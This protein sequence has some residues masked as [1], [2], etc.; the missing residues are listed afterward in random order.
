[1][2]RSF[3]ARARGTVL[4]AACAF[5]LSGC[6]TEEYSGFGPRHLQPLSPQILASIEQKGMAK[7]SPILLRLFKEES[8]REVWKQT[9]EGRFELLKSYPICRWSGELGPKIREGDRQAPEGF[10]SIT[11]E[12]MN[13]K[14]NFY[15]AFNLG[16][17]NEFDRALNRTGA[18]L[19][20]HGDCSSRGCYAMTDEQ[21]QE[22]FALGREAFD[23]GQLAFQ[24]QAYPFH[25]TAANMAR[26]RNSPHLVFWRML[27]EGN[28]HFELSRQQPKI[29]VCEK[30]YVYDAILN[31]PSKPFDPQRPCPAYEVPEQLAK[32]V[33][34]K[35]VADER[36]YTVLARLG[37]PTVPV[38][39]GRDGGMNPI[40]AGKLGP[41]SDDRF[42]TAATPATTGSAGP[43]VIAGVPLPPTDPRQRPQQSSLMS[44]AGSGSSSTR[45]ASASSGGFSFG[46]MFG[47]GG[48]EEKLEPQPQQ[49]AAAPVPAAP[50]K[51][52]TART[53]PT[54]AASTKAAAKPQTKAVQPPK[55]AP[56]PVEAAA[57][58][59]AP[60][61]LPAL[62]K[63][64]APPS[65]P[66][67]T[68]ILSSG[69]FSYN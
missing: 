17:P 1:M 10:Y 16:F 47:L 63:S 7:D 57:S 61:P 43:A 19:M 38:I 62:E 37:V 28:D 8:E 51:A 58:E 3:L 41:K 30:R 34:A 18:F 11:P 36:E 29:D 2:S 67:A 45:S 48:G 56:R 6:L 53:T 42:V 26:H 14:S 33:A 21:I 22:I 68:P 25:M 39:T 13:P 5:V 15:L 23:G 69:G 46:R 24:V 4:A 40:F 35:K 20:V 31:D 55:P 12:L 52:T 59:S 50:D 60:A 32:A 49:P 44:L 27:K 65:L 54:R 9:R 66:G 64:A